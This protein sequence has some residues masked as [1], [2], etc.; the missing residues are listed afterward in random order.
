MSKKKIFLAGHNGMVGS[1]IYRLLVQ[2]KNIRLVTREK[3]DLDLLDNQ[4]T[5]EFFEKQKFDEVYLAAAKV[6][7][8]LSNSLYPADFIYQNISIQNN[9]IHSCYE[10]KVKKLLFLGSSC[11][12]PRN[13]VQPISENSLLSGNLEKTNEPYALAKISGIKMCESYNIQY[14]TDY[15]SIMPTNLYGINDNFH[16]ENSHVIPGMIQRIHQA[17]QEN[18]Q[19]VFIWG[20][21]SPK[22]EF[23]H[24]SDM[25]KASLFIMSLSKDDYNQAT[26]PNLSHINVGWGIDYTIKELATMICNVIGYNGEIVFDLSKPDGTPRKVLDTQRINDLGW[27]PEINIKEGLLDTYK[28]YLENINAVRI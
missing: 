10:S 5:R 15:R 14:G 11:I 28:W 3:K 7:G 25:A 27:H 21:G 23:L 20:T 8:I 16:P 1:A 24:V 17:K 13:S 18:S 19:K 22:R 2:D 12:Y 9:V 6:G 4:Q 26:S